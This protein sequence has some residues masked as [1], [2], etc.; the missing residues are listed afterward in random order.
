MNQIPELFLLDEKKE[1]VKNILKNPPQFK[2]DAHQKDFC[3]CAGFID[4]VYR[5]VYGD[6]FTVSEEEFN[7]Q[8]FQ[9]FKEVSSPNF[10]DIIYVKTKDFF[11]L[12]VIINDY[13]VMHMTDKGVKVEPISI[14]LNKECK[15]L[16]F[17]K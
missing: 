15:F 2:K 12:G 7:K 10:F 1:S 11:H 16:R 13:N 4:N 3:D 8:I 6:N 5:N 14:F 9:G 17:V